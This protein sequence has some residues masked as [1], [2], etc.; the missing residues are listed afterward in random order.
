MRRRLAVF[1]A[2]VVVGVALGM[3]LTNLLWRPRLVDITNPD[4]VARSELD[5]GNLA[6]TRD[7]EVVERRETPYGPL[8]TYKAVCLSALHGRTRMYGYSVG[9]VVGSGEREGMG[10][11]SS[12]ETTTPDRVVDFSVGT[13]SDD[14]SGDVVI[15]NGQLLSPEAV[16]VE[17]VYGDGKVIR[18]QPEGDVF[19]LLATGTVRACQLRILDAEGNVL[20]ESELQRCRGVSLRHPLCLSNQDVSPAAFLDDAPATTLSRATSA[21]GRRAGSPS[22]R[23]FLF[24]YG[25]AWHGSASSSHHVRSFCQLQPAFRSAF[26]MV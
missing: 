14:R 21:G 6:V 2:L 15:I 25:T 17:A 3:L 18:E 26:Y 8:L 7:F 24:R 13:F 12:V 1:G 5:C 20:H 23:Q 9:K 16:V 22:D 10:G 19:A 11:Q 4:E